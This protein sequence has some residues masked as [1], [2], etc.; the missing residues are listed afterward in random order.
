[1]ISNTIGTSTYVQFLSHQDILFFR[2]TRRLRHKSDD[3]EVDEKGNEEEH[4]DPEGDEKEED[5]D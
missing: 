5:E 1:M 2:P 4:E 3:D